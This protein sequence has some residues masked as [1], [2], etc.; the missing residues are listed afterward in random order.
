MESCIKETT[1]T[2]HNREEFSA[3]VRATHEECVMLQKEV[4]QLYIEYND[5]FLSLSK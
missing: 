3:W 5:F 1:Q 4:K 2:E